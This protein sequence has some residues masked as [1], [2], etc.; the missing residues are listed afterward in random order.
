M[1]YPVC[2]K[3]IGGDKT[4]LSLLCSEI[5]EDGRV[6]SCALTNLTAH[7]TSAMDVNDIVT[8]PFVSS[9]V[10]TTETHYMFVVLRESE[11]HHNDVICSLI[12]PAIHRLR[13]NLTCHR[14]E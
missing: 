13:S 12:V 1:T 7:I 3:L 8:V 10:E 9:V 6:E 4:L 5:E 11:A 2:F 14:I